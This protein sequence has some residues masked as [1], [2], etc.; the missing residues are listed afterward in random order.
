MRERKLKAPTEERLIRSALHYLERYSTSEAN[1]RRV[2]ERKVLKAC[3]ALDLDPAEHSGMIDRVVARF[4]G[5]GLV[6]DRTFAETKIAGLR[7]RGG[8]ARKIAAQLGAKGVDR[9][10]ID[11][12]LETD[13]T[14]DL[15]AAR[16]FARRRR[17]GPFRTKERTE[18]RDRDLAAMCRAGFDFET[19]RQV[20]DAQDLPEDAQEEDQEPGASD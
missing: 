19:A 11:L 1:L 8:S 18:R 20:I 14:S 10:T 3:R 7:R 16:V 9:D 5:N 2:L 17:L 4:V 12:V 13:E 6:N 15:E